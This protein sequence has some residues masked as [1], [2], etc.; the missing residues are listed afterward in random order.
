MELVIKKM[1]LEDLDMLVELR[2]EVLKHVFHQEETE[3]LKD[4]NKEYY[5]T[6]LKDDTHIAAVG[7]LDDKAVCCGGVCFYEEMPSP[8]N[9]SGK[10]AYLMNVYCKKE[11]RHRGYGRAICQWLITQSQERADKIYLE[12]SKAAKKMYYNLY[13]ED[14]HDYLQLKE[15]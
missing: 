2:M 6:H 3:E 12:S 13:F 8:D 14:M 15:K 1:S 9:P 4:D 10:C 7:F 11:Y 5:K